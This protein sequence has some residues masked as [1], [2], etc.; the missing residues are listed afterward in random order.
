[1]H[2]QL[3][4]PAATQVCTTIHQPNSLISSKFG[5]FMLLHAG[6]CV[7]FGPWTSAVD[8]FAGA[9]CPCPQ[10]RLTPGLLLP[11]AV[12]QPGRQ[13]CVEAAQL[14]PHLYTLSP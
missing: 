11:H 1:M 14:Y 6:S 7:Y 12:A 3:H 10:V 8:Y 4:L 9:G 5:D 13:A 2:M